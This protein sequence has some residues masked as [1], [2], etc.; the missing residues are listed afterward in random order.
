MYVFRGEEKRPGEDQEAPRKELIDKL[1]WSYGQA[2]YLFTYSVCGLE[3]R[4]HAILPPSIEN[5]QGRQCKK[6]RIPKCSTFSLGFF[7]LGTIGGRLDLFWALV[8]ISPYLILIANLCPLRDRPE[9]I[10]TDEKRIDFE[11]KDG[12]SIVK[13][14]FPKEA[15][16]MRINHLKLVYDTRKQARVPNVDILIGEGSNYVL[17]CP[18]G[19]C[20]SKDKK[21]GPKNETELLQAL[22][23]VLEALV[24]LHSIGWMHRDIRWPNVIKQVD[25]SKWFL[26][27]FDDSSKSP[28]EN[29]PDEHLS[30]HEHPP[31]IFEPGSHSMSVDIWG[32]GYLI[33]SCKCTLSETLFG[34]GQRLVNSEPDNRPTAEQVLIKIRDY[35]RSHQN[36]NK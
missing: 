30:R 36:S 1:E 33:L 11:E 13:K 6:P 7:N 9:Y 24:V 31:E 21:K 4:L 18:V 17:L 8:N 23:S 3:L 15:A 14:T 2:P 26:I 20:L 27:D 16:S 25:S 32:V 12:M 5:E 19:D 28:K 34:F 29:C 10:C 22:E 35:L